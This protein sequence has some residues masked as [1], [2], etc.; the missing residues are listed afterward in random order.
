MSF[1][2]GWI[3]LFNVIVNSILSFYTSIFLILIFICFLKIK[4]PRIKTYCYALPFGKM[5]LDL[6]FYRF[7]NWALAM[8]I[9]PLL[10][11]IGSRTL[12]IRINPFFGIRLNMQNG[13]T[14]SPA[15]IIALSVDPLWIRGI[16]IIGVVG[17]FI[18][19]VLF[20]ARTIRDYQTICR[21]VL[22]AKPLHRAVL[23][24]SLNAFIRKKSI[25]CLITESIRSPCIFGRA[26]LFPCH[27]AGILSQTEFEAIIA[28]ELT[29][30]RWKDHI[31]RTLCALIAAIF[32]WLGAEWW[33]RRMANFQETAA[34]RAIHQF[35]ISKLALAK[36]ILKT[37]KNR[38]E[39]PPNPA[40]SLIERPI[41]FV[42]R[43]QMILQHGHDRRSKWKA[44]Q[45][46]LLASGLGAVLFGKMWI[47]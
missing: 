37:A 15:D 19:L 47:F 17:S 43:M 39:T 24:P 34:D 20:A 6:F 13:S 1:E 10:A 35:S 4:H 25:R 42:N 41:N 29:H 36:A 8:D 18:A 33:R 7:S 23:H 2:L 26:L 16:G 11:Q 30:L 38:H 31:T 45:Y 27:L 9:N 28:H 22:K 12:S 44:V 40:I 5:V 21:I 3:Y 14:F 32:W 46:G